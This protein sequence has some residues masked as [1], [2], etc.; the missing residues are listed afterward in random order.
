MPKKNETPPRRLPARFGEQIACAKAKKTEIRGKNRLPELKG[1][2]SEGKTG[3]LC[4][5]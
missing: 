5:K 3:I 1:W 4:E 2:L